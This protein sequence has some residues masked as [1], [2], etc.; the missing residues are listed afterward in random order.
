MVA[1]TEWIHT[2]RCIAYVVVCIHSNVLASTPPHS[3]GL[4]I[5]NA[6]VQVIFTHC[7]H[8]LLLVKTE[9]LNNTS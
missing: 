6:V 8:S 3:G 7:Y 4:R 5:A 9:C 2:Y 1:N